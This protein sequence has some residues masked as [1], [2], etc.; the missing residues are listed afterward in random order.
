MQIDLEQ[1]N[2]SVLHCPGPFQGD[3][4]ARREAELA[5]L[6]EPHLEDIDAM[7]HANRYIAVEMAM[8]TSAGATT[9]SGCSS[10]QH[11]PA[12]ST[13]PRRPAT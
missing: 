11:V 12:L 13:T 3:R 8:A 10:V 5:E 4:E 9:R 2:H 1:R 7:D 6:L